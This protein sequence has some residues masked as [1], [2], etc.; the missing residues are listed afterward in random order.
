MAH[1]LQK[2]HLGVPIGVFL[3]GFICMQY[4]G[5]TILFMDRIQLQPDSQNH[6][7]RVVVGISTFS[8]RIFHIGP[9][10]QSIY[11]QTRRADRIIVSIPK[12]HRQAS[13]EPTSCFGWELECGTDS[14]QH[15]ESRPNVLNWFKQLTNTTSIKKTGPDTFEFPGSLTV[16]FLDQDWGAGTKALGALML[17]HDPATILITMDDDMI[18]HKETIAYLAKHETQGMALSFGCETWDFFHIGWVGHSPGHSIFTLSFPGARICNGWLSGWTAV[19]Y[20]V[21]HFGPDIWTFLDSL[22]RG[23][24]YNDD[25]WLSAYLARKGIPRVYVPGVIVPGPHHRDEKLSLSTIVGSREKY[26]YPC[27]RALFG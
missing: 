14:K 11:T 26:G 8:Q 10:I 1:R 15:D 12:V 24:F 20:R 19:A 4:L 16:L 22:P 25:V 7:S 13:A 23:C 6:R 9:T 18:Y 2:W 3:M 17:E 5:A 27:A 21:G